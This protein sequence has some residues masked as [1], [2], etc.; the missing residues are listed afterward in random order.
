MRKVGDPN[1]GGGKSKK[2]DLDLDEF[3]TKQKQRT[4]R[5]MRTGVDKMKIQKFQ[6]I[7]SGS[8]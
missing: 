7:H 2:T 3:N 4:K 1:G 6:A 5:I 8:Q